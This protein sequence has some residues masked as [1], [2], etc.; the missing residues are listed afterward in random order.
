MGTG[1]DDAQVSASVAL[2]FPEDIP[3]GIFAYSAQELQ[4]PST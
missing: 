3:T 2:A 4:V 1:W